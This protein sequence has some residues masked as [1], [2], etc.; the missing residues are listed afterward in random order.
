[1]LAGIWEGNVMSIAIND[2][3]VMLLLSIVFFPV[4]VFG[5]ILAFRIGGLAWYRSPYLFYVLFYLTLWLLVGIFQAI[6]PE[7]WARVMFYI[8]Y[9]DG[10]LLAFY[11]VQVL[12][13]HRHGQ[14]ARSAARAGVRGS[15]VKGGPQAVAQRCS[16]PLTLEERV[17]RLRATPRINGATSAELDNH[18]GT[19]PGRR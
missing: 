2:I 10:L 16:A 19:P 3:V 13:R 7:E 8:L 1:M 12:F 9:G 18:R 17:R 14:P 11:G 5:I 4:L 6:L 15:G